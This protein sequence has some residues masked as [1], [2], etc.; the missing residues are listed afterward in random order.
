MH[1]KKEMILYM[2]V[3]FNFIFNYGDWKTLQSEALG[4]AG[5]RSAGAARRRS[6]PRGG[7]GAELATRRRDT[8]VEVPESCCAEAQP[9]RGAGR[10]TEPLAK[11]CTGTGVAG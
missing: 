2:K 6:W 5:T 9:R 10:G 11:V 3:L 8:R 7:R 1:I 4:A